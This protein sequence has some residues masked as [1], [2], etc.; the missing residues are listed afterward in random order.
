M[1]GKPRDLSQVCRPIFPKKSTM[2]SVKGRYQ[3]SGTAVEVEKALNALARSDK[4][5]EATAA[6][7][8]KSAGWG[9]GGITLSG[10]GFF[11]VT[12]MGLSNSAFQ[13]FSALVGLVFLASL[14]YM[15]YHYS[16]ASQASKGDIDDHRY[17]GLMRLHNLV[18]VD[19]APT[20]VF[21]YKLDF[22]S[23]WDPAFLQSEEKFGGMFSYPKGKFKFYS[24]PVL[25]ARVK[26]KDGA[27]LKITAT[28]DSRVKDYQKKNPRGKVKSKWKV[29][30]KD[31]FRV[32]VKLPGQVGGSVPQVSFPSNAMGHTAK[33]PKLKVE[34]NKVSAVRV[35]KS[36]LHSFDIEPALRLAVWVFQNLKRA[37]AA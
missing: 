31:I 4:E 26:L 33:P 15:L 19:C 1:S 2:E 7:H 27:V 16:K 37:K 23:Y 30:H 3:I 14:V 28:R 34:G 17:E 6:A 36:G 5:S 35:V 20:A 21:D 10:V 12:N 22:S 9:C 25:V 11:G 32:D 24:M 18:K 8:N 29:K 13:L